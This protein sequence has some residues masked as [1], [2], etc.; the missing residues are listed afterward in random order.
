M[1]HPAILGRAFNREI[2][3][4][5]FSGNGKMEPKVTRFFAEHNHAALG[6]EFAKFQ[7]EKGA[8]SLLLESRH[9]PRL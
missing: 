6:E 5:G 4:L 9:P 8:P 2:I 3:N 1:T 7:A